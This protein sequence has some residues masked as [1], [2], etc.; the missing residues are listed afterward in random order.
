[1]LIAPYDA[2]ILA[3]LRFGHPL[4]G[5]VDQVGD[6]FR[7]LAKR[8]AKARPEERET[9]WRDGLE[10]LPDEEAERLVEA[11][12]RADP[13]SSPPAVGEPDE[14]PP[15][16]LGMLPPVDPFPLDVFPDPV[17]RIALEA[18]TAVGCDVG[19]VACPLL[20]IAA[21]LIGRS[22]SLLLG[23]NWFAS[24]SLF[25]ANVAL[26]GDGKSPSLKYAYT[27]IRIIDQELADE[28]A[29][30]KKAHK[31]SKDNPGPPPLPRRIVLED[32]TMESIGRKLA[33]NGRGLV[34][35]YDELAVLLCG[36]GQYKSGRGNDRANLLK[37]WAGAPI[38]I[39]R[40]LNE[41]GEPIRIPHPQLSIVG[42]LPPATLSELTGARGDDGLLDR[43][44]FVYPD[45]R[46]KLKAS[47]RRP[48]SNTTLD[49]WVDVARRLWE[50]S[51]ELNDGRLCPNVVFFTNEGKREFD[52][53]DDAH[54]DEMNSSEFPDWLRGPWSKLQEY[55]GRLCLVLTLLRHASNLYVDQ[56]AIPSA[57]TVDARD[58]WRLVA[59]FKS[60]HRRVRA[61]LQGKG[62][63]G[64]PEGSRLLLNWLK[65]H[66]ERRSF[67]ARDIA[68]SYPPSRGYDR[69]M[70][71]DGLTWL[72]DRNV[73]RLAQTTE[74]ADGAPGRKP[75]PVWDVHPDLCDAQ[76]N[77]QFQQNGG[78][79]AE[80]ADTAAH[81]EEEEGPSWS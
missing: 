61:Y 5:E 27:P 10:A 28:F 42:N 29:A 19:M 13:E 44:L 7:L 80:S 37:M 11:V 60:H 4:N 73:I 30:E 25:L 58:A 47:Q 67:A 45:R 79:F 53:W 16:R 2:W 35:I 40:V 12:S 31:E 39:D 34:M 8:L 17:M 56:S 57:D 62:L 71:E 69:A 41:S 70:M 26:P 24:S 38:L 23:S 48:V 3:R 76:R 81:A 14:W 36:L 43:W 55:A 22:A 74:R 49:E 54:V 50:R 59:F 52:R 63:A 21:G 32:V 72:K 20:G 1:M 6:L 46:P 78:R 68:R 65:N 75:S 15:L 51:M 9:I 33:E 64:A 66:S 18:S 77:Q